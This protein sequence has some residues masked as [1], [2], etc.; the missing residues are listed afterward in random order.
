MLFGNCHFESESRC[1]YFATFRASA[2][3]PGVPPLQRS[4]DGVDPESVEQCCGQASHQHTVTAP[5]SR[6]QTLEVL[7]HRPLQQEVLHP[8]PPE[9][10]LTHLPAAINP[11]VERLDV[12]ELD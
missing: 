2:S 10:P 6:H 8:P 7:L 5:S 3:E 1:F 12:L 11:A 4:E 9:E